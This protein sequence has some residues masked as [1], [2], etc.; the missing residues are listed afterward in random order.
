[1]LIVARG[2]VQYLEPYRDTAL[3]ETVPH[4]RNVD[5]YAC[6]AVCVCGFLHGVCDQCL[7]AQRKLL[8]YVLLLHFPRC[9]AWL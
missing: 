6:V 4:A 9:A 5:M 8:D 7:T 2:G 3:A 1:M